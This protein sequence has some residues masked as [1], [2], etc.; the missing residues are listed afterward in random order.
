MQLVPHKAQ[1]LFEFAVEFLYGQVEGIVGK[2]LAPKAFPLLATMFIFILVSN[3]LGLFPGVG[4]IG[5]DHGHGSHFGSIKHVETA[6]LRPPSADL[7]LTLGMALCFMLYWGWVTV[8]EVGVW[9]FIKHTF[10]P[11]GVKGPVAVILGIFVFFP[12]GVIEM[13]SIAFRPVSLSLRLFGNVYAGETLL[14]AMSTL[15]DGMG[16]FGAFIGSVLFPLPFYF[17]EILVGLLQAMVFSLLCAVYIK[18]SASHD[19]EH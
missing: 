3:W 16:A 8:R 19:E 4:T 13:V 1:N 9:G 12:V 10:A 6:L 11:K 5:W 15:G 14:H 17:M 7:N 2:H 18:L